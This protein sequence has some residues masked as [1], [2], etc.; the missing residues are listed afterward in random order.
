MG[1]SITM[2]K[3]FPVTCHTDYVGLGST[4]VAIAGVSL[5]GVAYVPQAI[6][7]G[8]SLIVLAE[9]AHV[10]QD[11]WRLM[12]D[13]HVDIQRVA[14]TRKALAILSAQAA[15]HPAR[16]LKIIGITGTKGKTTTAFL[17]AHILQRAGKKTA[18][19][20]TVHN[21]I[22]DT[23]FPPS[24]TTPQ[25]DYLHQFLKSCVHAGVEYVV[26]EVAAQ[27]LSLH[28]VHD[29]LFDGIIFTNFSHEHLEFYPT[30]DAYFAAKCLIFDHAKEKAPVLINA[31]DLLCTS[32]V[33]NNYQGFGLHGGTYIKAEQPCAIA[34]DESIFSCPALIGSFNCYNILAAVRMALAHGFVKQDVADSLQSFPG[35]PG[36]LQQFNM[37]NGARCIIDYAHNPSSYQAVLSMLRAQTDNLI[38]VFGAGG[39]RDPHKR[40]IMGN[41]AATFADMVI[42]TSDNPRTEDPCK[43]MDAIAA[44]IENK[45]KVVCEVDRQEAIK[46]AYK[47]SKSGSIIAILGKGT[48]EYQIIGS[49]K[50]AFSERKIIEALC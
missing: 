50:K 12:R 7:N 14:D 20:S 28:R 32:L 16:Q 15:N 18:L 19:M 29:I 26:M 22:M 21:K 25:P 44:G 40:P 39:Q 10:P 36:R 11:T 5:D 17:L 42:L 2:P 46:L 48:D 38:V 47:K 31:N 23:T 27:A 43:I 41:I 6:E 35:V 37:P 49:E 33:Q 45:D 4:F 34:I 1:N 8:A 24:L 9:D 13:A 3:I 30:I